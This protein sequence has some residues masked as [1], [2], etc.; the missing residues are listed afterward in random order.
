[1]TQIKTYCDHCGK[2]LNEMTDMTDITIDMETRAW[3]TDLCTKC[4]DE[5]C[6]LA[7]DFCSYGERKGQE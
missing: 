6:T 3:K 1:M 2:L 5:L 4:F 7:S